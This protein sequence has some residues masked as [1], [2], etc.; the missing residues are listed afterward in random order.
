MPREQAAHVQR[1]VHSA[2]ASCLRTSCTAIRAATIPRIGIG[3]ALQLL[4]GCRRLDKRFA[5]LLAI[6]DVDSDDA[7]RDCDWPRIQSGHP[8][9]IP[10]LSMLAHTHRG[11]IF[12][13]R[14]L[15][16]D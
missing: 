12:E 10:V 7:N 11:S 5:R 13:R 16:F 1:R 14:P 8:C 3:I 6:V 15:T 4:A 9:V 2:C